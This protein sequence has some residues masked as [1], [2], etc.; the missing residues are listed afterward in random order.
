MRLLFCRGRKVQSQRRAVRALDVSMFPSVRLAACVSSCWLCRLRVEI[1]IL[2]RP[3][4]R[5]MVCDA[6]CAKAG[7]STCRSCAALLCS[8]LCW[9]WDSIP[10]ACQ[11]CISE[12]CVLP[13]C[14][15]SLGGEGRR[16]KNMVFPAAIR[17]KSQCWV[18]LSC[19]HTRCPPVWVG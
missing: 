6:F 2:S 10:R 12:L 7:F 9:Y 3:C 8:I 4:A 11:A 16:C 15:V 1:R 19:D 18:V 5:G 17:E 14:D 13:Q